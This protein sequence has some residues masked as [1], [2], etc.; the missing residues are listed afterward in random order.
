MFDLVQS[1][2]LVDSRSASVASSKLNIADDATSHIE[3]LVARRCTQQLCCEYFRKLVAFLFSTV[4]SC[5]LMVGYVILG[6]IIF[7]RLEAEQ[8][9]AID[10]D[11]QSMKEKHV[12]WLWNLTAT[13][14]VLHPHD[15]S[16]AAFDVLNSYTTQVIYHTCG[17]ASEDVSNF[18]LHRYLSDDRSLFVFSLVFD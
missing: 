12:D 6:G 3:S 15:W 4:G 16:T 13:M 2:E 17:T 7:H 18:S 8:G 11:M 10:V 9:R 1:V 14:N 5:C